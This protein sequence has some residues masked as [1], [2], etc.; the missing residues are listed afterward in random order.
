MS[1]GCKPKGMELNASICQVMEI[2]HAAYTVG[3][4]ILSYST[5][6]RILGVHV[7]SNLRT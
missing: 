3:G 5:T 2:T 6:E 4:T 1:A 7:S